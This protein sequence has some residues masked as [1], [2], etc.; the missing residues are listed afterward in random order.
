MY[1][2]GGKNRHQYRLHLLTTAFKRKL[3]GEMIVDGLR[4]KHIFSRILQALINPWR[5]WQMMM[6]MSLS[7]FEKET[8][9][10]SNFVCCFVK[11]QNKW[12]IELN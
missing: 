9:E 5:F 2:L 11:L 8:H 7:R 1:F 4:S 10:V 12:R 6:M 3:R